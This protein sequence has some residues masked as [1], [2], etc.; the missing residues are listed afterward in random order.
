[1]EQPLAIVLFGAH[2][3]GRQE[4]IAAVR[5]ANCVPVLVLHE[6]QTLDIPSYLQPFVNEL[7]ALPVQASEEDFQSLA[8]HLDMHYRAWHVLPLDDYVCQD[9]ARLSNFSKTVCFPISA[10]TSTFH[11][12]RLRELWNNWVSA[13]N[14]PSYGKVDC[15]FFEPSDPIQV[16]WPAGRYIVKP[17]AYAGS[18]GVFAAK[19]REVVQAIEQCRQTLAAE[20]ANPVMAGIQVEQ[21]VL[22]EQY[23]PRN[24]NLGACAEYTAHMVSLA[25]KHYLIGIAEKTIHPDTFIETGH[26]YPSNSFPTSLIPAMEKAIVGVLEQLG[27]ENTISNWE[28]IISPE[29]Q[30]VLVEGQL[31]P[32][33]DKVMNLIQQAHEADLY[34]FYLESLVSG[35]TFEY[36]KAKSTSLIYWPGPNETLERIDWIQLPNKLPPQVKLFLDRPALIAANNWQGPLSW[37]DRHIAIM[38]TATSA[39]EGHIKIKE[40][41]SK[42]K[43]KSGR[44]SVG[45]I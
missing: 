16:D 43:L 11:K 7:F 8:N 15:W 24:A 3:W 10:A 37:Y 41:C 4:V 13:V 32:S 23:I 12:H 18:V 40:A 27:A 33:G 19:E 2:R 31:R 1:M 5:D 34:A 42:I 20:A 30:L 36:P 21:S 26:Q 17:N 6:N 25:G 38:V 9:A 29:N 35:K 22:V 14:E 39:E 45:L 28:F 44:R